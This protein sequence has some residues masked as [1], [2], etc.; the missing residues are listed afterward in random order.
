MP[1]AESQLDVKVPRERATVVIALDVSGSMQATDVAPSRLTAAKAAAVRFVGS[2]P[3]T[4]DV[5]QVSFSSAATVQVAPTQDH[6]SV[7][8]AIDALTYGGGTAIGDAVAASVSAAQGVAVTAGAARLGHRHASCC[9]PTAGTP[10]EHLQRRRDE[11]VAEIVELSARL[12]AVVARLSPSSPR[13]DNS[14]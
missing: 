2:L 13:A 8:G 10:V 11:L 4:F 1:V 7:A 9:C 6:A 5:G 3:R 14:G 12:L